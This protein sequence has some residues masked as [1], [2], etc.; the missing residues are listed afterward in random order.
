M[1]SRARRITATLAVAAGLA[2]IGLLVFALV[3]RS[4]SAIPTAVAV[5]DQFR[6]TVEADGSLKSPDALPLSVPPEAV[7]PARLAWIAPDGS[8]VRAGEVV[9]RFDPTEVERGRDRARDEIARTDFESTRQRVEHRATLAG[10]ERDAEAARLEAELGSRFASKDPDLFSRREI[11]ESEIDS[12]LA[13]KKREH[14]E[15]VEKHEAKLAGLSEDL[16]RLERKKNELQLT[17]METGLSSLE[18]RAPFDGLFVLQ[19]SWRGDLPRVGDQVWPG[20]K[21]AE[22][23]NLGRIGAEVFVL[24]ADAGSLQPGAAAT[25]V[26]EAHPE[27]PFAAKVARVA[28]LA[29]PRRRASPVQYFSV[30]L[31]IEKPDL[32]LLAPGLR[33]RATLEATAVDN[34]VLVPRQALFEKEGKRVVYRRRGA[35]FDAV[36]VEVGPVGLGQVVIEHGIEAGDVVALVDPEA[37]PAPAEAPAEGGLAGLPGSSGSATE[38]RP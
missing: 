38:A 25:L 31:E 14:A 26:V 32:A 10:L 7:P 19:R 27:R 3:G 15:A 4:G 21:L 36:E 33:V 5:R 24:E 6:L 9:L 17:R 37:A 16:L 20:Q 11:I 18:V 23:P 30:D 1:T 2:L 35:S 28:K 13:T 8:R 29:K 22:L 34:A 12:E